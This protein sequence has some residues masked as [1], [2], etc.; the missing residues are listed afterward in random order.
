MQIV[1]YCPD[2]HFLYDGAT[3]DQAGVGG[4][5]TVRIRI[6]AALA[7]RGHRVSVICNCSRQA[8]HRGVLYRP[9]ASVGRIQA[10]VLVMHSSGGGIDLTPLLSIPIETQVR[11]FL[12]SGL[13]VAK[14]VHELNPD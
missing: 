10:D 12:L 5:L 13:D 14:R 11:I 6:A 1:I 7:Q 3:P 2:R 9:L 4:G 8:V